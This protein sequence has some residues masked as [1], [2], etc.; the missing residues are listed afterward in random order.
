MTVKGADETGYAI[1]E[2]L[3]AHTTRIYTFLIIAVALVLIRQV[4]LNWL[5]QYIKGLNSRHN[6]VYARVTTPHPSYCDNCLCWVN[7]IRAFLC[8]VIVGKQRIQLLLPPHART[9]ASSS[10][11][12]SWRHSEVF[13]TAASQN[14]GR[15]YHKQCKEYY[16]MYTTLLDSL[17]S[18]FKRQRSESL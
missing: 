1:G 18:E 4:G 9:L 5:S 6:W 11:W 17:G 10:K 16:D 12:L 15:K 13:V 2:A 14:A 3:L 7:V 8:D